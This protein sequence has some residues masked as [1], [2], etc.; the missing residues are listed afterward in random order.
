MIIGT[1]SN[2]RG[3]K[4]TVRSKNG[5]CTTANRP[6]QKIIPFEVASA[7][8]VQQ[9]QQSNEVDQ[10][11]VQPPQSSIEGV[12]DTCTIDKAQSSSRSKRRAAIIGEQT[13]RLQDIYTKFLGDI[14]HI[15]VIYFFLSGRM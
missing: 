4:L 14:C 8:P 7:S 3:V 10:S 6:V 12:D 11:P 2:I 9:T 15:V 1:D 5:K 13:R